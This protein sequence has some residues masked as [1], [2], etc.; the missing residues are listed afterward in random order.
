[1]LYKFIATI[2]ISIG[3]VASLSFID[4][5]VPSNSYWEKINKKITHSLS[6]EDYE[7]NKIHIA[8]DK[9]VYYEIIESGIRKGFLTISKAPSKYHFFDFFVVFDNNMHIEHIEILKYRENWGYEIS[10]KRWLRQFSRL[11]KNSLGSKSQIQAISGA[12]ISVNSLCHYIDI[13]LDDL[14]EI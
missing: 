4:S 1:M 10:N 6:L 5:W 11:T 2:S 8:N 3:V 7:I 9:I 14:E 13:M 12:T